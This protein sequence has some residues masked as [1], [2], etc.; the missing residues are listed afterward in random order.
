MVDPNTLPDIAQSV[1][2]GL[3]VIIT[4]LVR[5]LLR[6]R[7]FGKIRQHQEHKYS[8]KFT[9]ERCRHLSEVRDIARDIKNKSANGEC[10]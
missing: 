3:G 6:D 1:S 5:D 7:K 8:C 9:D 10:E 4:L 2:T